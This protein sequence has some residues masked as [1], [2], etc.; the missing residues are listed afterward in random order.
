MLKFLRY[1]TVLVDVVCFLGGSVIL[2]YS[3]IKI[4]QFYSILLSNARGMVME[5]SF[6][7]YFFIA[8]IGVGLIVLGFLTRSWLNKKQY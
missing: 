6:K 4:I 3:L 1:L 8:P 5:S 2:T 7:I